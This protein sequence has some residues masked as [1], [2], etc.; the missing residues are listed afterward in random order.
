MYT[1]VPVKS[2]KV[3]A[4]IDLD[5]FYAQVRAPWVGSWGSDGTRTAVQRRAARRC[6]NHDQAIF[7][8]C[9]FMW[10]QHG[11]ASMGMHLAVPAACRRHQSAPRTCYRTW[12]LVL[13]PSC[14]SKL[15]PCFYSMLPLLPSDS[16]KHPTPLYRPNCFIL[17]QLPPPTDPSTEPSP[18]MCN[19]HQVESKRNPELKGKPLVV[20]QCVQHQHT[21][22]H[23]PCFC[24]QRHL[25]VVPAQQQLGCKDPQWSGCCSEAV[26]SAAR[27][28]VAAASVGSMLHMACRH[29]MQHCR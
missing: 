4:H 18:A 27:P 26:S 17:A 22:P 29:C 16:W 23:V 13:G 21:L 24:S 2:T 8:M 28:L 9:C 12:A 7:V 1:S 10:M 15:S 25:Q 5:A 11:D 20:V 14:Q 3:I 6:C 19:T